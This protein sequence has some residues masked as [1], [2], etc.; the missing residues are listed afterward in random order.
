MGWFWPLG[1]G[2][3]DLFLATVVVAA[4]SVITLL[5]VQS[6]EQLTIWA[7]GEPIVRVKEILQALADPK[8]RLAPEFW[9][10]YAM[11]FSTLLP[12][13]F[14]VS[15]GTLSLLRGAPWL[16][17]RLARRM[18]IG[19]A[20]LES[21]RLWMAP[22][23]AMQVMLSIIAGLAAMIGL[24]WIILILELPFVGKT[25]VSWLQVVADADLP[26]AVMRWLGAN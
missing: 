26:L 9:W 4:L 15:L 22:V 7:G 8:R 3:L 16:R 11:L 21:E 5:A 14:N 10:I 6:F 17:P 1:V 25:L 2:L 24:I 20:V 18:P 19:K 13:I 23:L 12:S